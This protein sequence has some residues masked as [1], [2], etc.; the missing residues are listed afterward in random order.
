MLQG[1]HRSSE[2]SLDSDGVL[3][4]AL[5]ELLVMKPQVWCGPISCIAY[6]SQT[7]RCLIPGLSLVV[8]NLLQAIGGSAEYFQQ[9]VHQ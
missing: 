9:R 5:V 3:P 8:D 6:D 4:I 2:K 7:D 1:N